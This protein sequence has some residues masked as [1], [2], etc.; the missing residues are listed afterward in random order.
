M[1]ATAMLAEQS[2]MAKYH[3]QAKRYL[4]DRGRYESASADEFAKVAAYLRHQDFRRAIEPYSRQRANIVCSWYALQAMPV[5][6][7]MMPAA[8]KEAVA[9]W[10]EMISSVAKQFGYQADTG[11]KHGG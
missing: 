3:A 5:S 9:M 6:I 7:D 2:F 8:L 4:K 10:D 11:E 1:N